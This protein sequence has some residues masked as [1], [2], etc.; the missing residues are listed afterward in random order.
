MS[1][2]ILRKIFTIRLILIGLLTLIVGISFTVSISLAPMLVNEVAKH[3]LDLDIIIRICLLFGA[4]MLVQS[5]LGYFDM[6][7]NWLFEIR[8][9]ANL[10]KFIFSNSIIHKS[11]TLENIEETSLIIN[12][13]EDTE[14]Y[15]EFLIGVVRYAISLVIYSVFLSYL[16]NLASTIIAI[17]MC[18]ILYVV[19]YKF[20]KP[21]AQYNEKYLQAKAT[22]LTNFTKLI[23]IRS[24]VIADTTSGFMMEHL[25]EIKQEQKSYFEFKKAE[26]FSS[27][28]NTLLF[29]L[30]QLLCLVVIVIIHSLGHLTLGE[31]IAA[32]Q[33]I[34]YISIVQTKILDNVTLIRG[35]R[36]AVNIIN[37]YLSSN[38]QN[39]E[40]QV[41]FNE[42]IAV[43]NLLI[44]LE[45]KSIACVNATFNHGDKILLTG[46]NGSGKSN[47]LKC[48]AN[49][50]KNYTG[51]ILFD[52]KEIKDKS[53]EQI[54]YYQSNTPVIFSDNFINN[55]T[56]FNSYKCDEQ[57]VQ[58]LLKKFDFQEVLEVTDCSTL[59]LAERQAIEFIRVI[60]SGRKLLIFDESFS[61]LDNKNTKV[62]YDYLLNKEDITII[63]VDHSMKKPLH[64]FTI[65]YSIDDGEVHLG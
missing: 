31:G 28:V 64:G 59:T 12:N 2:G 62:A 8:L 6:R 35:K 3:I 56:V 54:V 44:P 58:E 30:F 15:Y 32:F 7:L 46:Q 13:V 27:V 38:V 45:E 10:R 65:V 51:S 21:L 40:E 57:L 16:A 52:D 20:T 39:D 1:F 63:V 34:Q 5:V 41:S 24:N 29:H 9:I 37:K 36:G 43:K 26:N 11:K 42:K 23:S 55:V 19:A 18:L 48:L 61:S 50:N 22:Y 25:D 47:F 33:F 49:I 53:T 17:V 4:T 14:D 60:N